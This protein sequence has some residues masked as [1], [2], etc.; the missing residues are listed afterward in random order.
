MVGIVDPAGGKIYDPC[1]GSG[2][3]LIGTANYIRNK[4]GN[5]QD[6]S[7][8]GQEY[9]PDARKICQMNLIL[10]NIH[11]DL[12]VEA[13][14]TLKG[15]PYNFGKADFI[16]ANPPFNQSDWGLEELYDD[17]RWKYGIPPKGNA[18]F[19][20]LQDGIYHLDPEGRMGMLLSNSSLFSR[21]HWEYRIRKNI[22]NADLIEGIITLPAR[23]FYNT[24]IP[25]SIWLI[26]KNKT[27]KGYSLFVDA[28]KLETRTGNGSLQEL[29]VESMGRI[30][31]TVGAF[32]SSSLQDKRGFCIAVD[33]K[34]IKNQDYILTPNAYLSKL[35]PSSLPLGK[36]DRLLTEQKN[37][38]NRNNVIENELKRI[39]EEIDF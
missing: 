35:E 31:E 7:F 11:T 19:A 12:G 15:S 13:S 1:C 36:K 27:R 30:I 32:R 18:N 39:L 14:D 17:E 6:T 2:G 37:L 4:Y 21:N 28:Q 34:S 33:N 3:F 23:L 8:Y 25:V 5:L 29:T 10:N 16:L 9:N 22:A 38:I 20:F 24:S 26:T